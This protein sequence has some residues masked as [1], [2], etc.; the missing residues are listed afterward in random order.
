VEDGEAQEMADFQV[1]RFCLINV[2]TSGTS[3]QLVICGQ[4]NEATV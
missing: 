1:T 3:E 2:I 4:V